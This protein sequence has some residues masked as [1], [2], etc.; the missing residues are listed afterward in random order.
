MRRRA[1]PC[2]AAPGFAVQRKSLSKIN[3]RPES[4]ITR[5]MESLNI[6]SGPVRDVSRPGS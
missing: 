2:P 5:N 3:Y 6:P 1:F 4:P